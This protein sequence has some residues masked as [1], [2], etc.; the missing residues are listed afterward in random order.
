[1][2]WCVN[3][4]N[5][6]ACVHWK[7]PFSSYC[8]VTSGSHALQHIY[9][10]EMNDHTKLPQKPQGHPV[11]EGRPLRVA[12]IG[13]GVSGIAVYI[14]LLQYVPNCT[15]TIFEKNSG[16]G[17]TWFE[18]R[19]P[20]V[21][22]DIPSHVYQYS[23][24]PNPRWSKFFSEGSEILEYIQSVGAKYGVADKIKYN[25][26][27]TAASWDDQ[28]GTWA[29]KTEHTEDSGKVQAIETTAEIVIS[30]VGILN[31]W[32]WPDIDGLHSFKGALLH[33]ANWDTSWYIAPVS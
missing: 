30:A 17:G 16:L 26:R 32:K 10:K 4:H 3:C 21:A 14:R 28:T 2:I 7:L 13:G 33:S 15:I 22:C 8:F 20:G 27:V 23:F 24:E 1:M 29:V 11:D 18:N 19:Y 12:I 25:T 5:R 9:T 6:Q 31:N